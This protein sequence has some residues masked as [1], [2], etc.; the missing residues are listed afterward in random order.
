MHNLYIKVENGV[1]VSHP[2][3]KDNLLQAFGAIPVNWEPFSRVEKPI[4]K[5][6]QLLESPEPV[7]T[8]LA[9]IW[10]DVW[11]PCR[12]MTA[13]EKAV[14]QQVV[15]DAWAMRDQAANW[16]AWVF[17]E[18]TCT[19]LPPIPRPDAG[20]Y[21]WSGADNNWKEAPAMPEGNHKFDFT[22]WVW[23]AV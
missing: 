11:L 19:V 16:A 9:G 23:V 5:V 4:P 10:T 13:E 21:R 7:Y 14:K 6:Y 12:D 17:D 20:E 18:V 2:A 3:Y 15:K 22:Q 8:K 1:I